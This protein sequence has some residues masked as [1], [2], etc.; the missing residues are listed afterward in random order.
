MQTLVRETHVQM[1]AGRKGAS[2]HS[3]FPNDPLQ[4]D[5]SSNCCLGRSAATATDGASMSGSG[6]GW[7]REISDVGVSSLIG[8]HVRTEV[9]A[10]VTL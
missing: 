10:N 9:E 1:L 7:F 5:M 8:K 3:H 4:P 2:V 6:R